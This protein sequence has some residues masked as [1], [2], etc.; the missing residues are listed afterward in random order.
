MESK[1][2]YYK[3]QLTKLQDSEFNKSLK[4]SDGIGNQTNSLGLN[5]ESIPVLIKFLENELKKLKGE[6]NG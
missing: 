6:S 4:L 1:F 5:L 2:S 3:D